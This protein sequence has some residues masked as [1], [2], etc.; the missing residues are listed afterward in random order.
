MPSKRLKGKQ[1]RTANESKSTSE[2]RVKQSP[3]QQ[4]PSLVGSSPTANLIVEV[5]IPPLSKTQTK[6]SLP[7][8]ESEEQIDHVTVKRPSRQVKRTKTTVISDEEDSGS[9][10]NDEESTKRNTQS[11]GL[12]DE[13]MSVIVDESDASDRI[14]PKAKARTKSNSKPKPVRKSKKAQSTDDEMDV[15]EMPSGGRRG[16]KRKSDVMASEEEDEDEGDDGKSRKKVKKDTKPKVSRAVADPWKLK[17]SSV[18]K[19]WREMQAPPLEMF[20]F[21]RLVI[22][23]YTYLDG[24]THSLITNLQATCRWVLS[25]TPPVHDFPSLKTIAVFLDVHLGIDDDGEGQSAQVKKR[26]REQTGKSFLFVV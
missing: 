20:H 22:D 24:K 15:D 19:N 9:E 21:H 7:V 6:S 18:K 17:S 13:D 3:P 16:K 11:S 12:E 10:Y 26:R 2:E 25:G 4:Q 1:Y 14:K 5:V 23:E 8:R